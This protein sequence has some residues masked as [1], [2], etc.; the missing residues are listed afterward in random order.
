M[1]LPYPRLAG[2]LTMSRKVLGLDIRSHRVCAVL[3]KSSL[4]E[5]RILDWRVVPIASGEA[6]GGGLAA[7]LKIVR[8]D[9]IGTDTDCAVCVPAALFSCRNLQLPFTNTQKIRM[10][11]PMELESHLPPAGAEQL[12]DFAVADSRSGDAPQS[13][14][15]AAAVERERLTPFLEALAQTG[16]DPERVTISGLPFAAAIG[17]RQGPEEVTLCADIGEGFGA[18]AVLTGERIRLLRCFALPAAPDAREQVLATHVRTMLGAIQEHGDLPEPSARLFLTGDGAAGMELERRV[19]SLPVEVQP[20][21]LH[22]MLNLALP[23]GE[24]EW[25]PARMNGALALAMGEIEGLESLNFHRSG[26]PGRKL[27]ARYRESLVR[28]GALAAAVLVLMLASVLTQAFVLKRQ[29]AGLDRQIAA[30]FKATFP[31]AKSIVDPYR[32]MQANLQE[33]RKSAA[34]GGDGGVNFHSIEVLKRI[35]EAI[36]DEIAVVFERMVA[37]P[38]TILISGTTGG[39]NAVDEIKGHLER[40]PGFKKVT[41]SS[42]NTDRTGKEVNFQLKVDL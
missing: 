28:T 16:I 8:A 15:V 38:E 17:R 35:S 21:D 22:P 19:R 41:I 37:G 36:P 9:M 39:F 20:V 40:V 42:A 18:I 30:V 13:E 5:S 1:D 29:A 12:I 7:A 2:E 4:R 10:V 27:I 14:V 31:E 25:E 6:E 32:Q 11:L 34:A 23:E 26:F 33:F 3:V 24:E